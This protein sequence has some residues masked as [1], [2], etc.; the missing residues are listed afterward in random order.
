MAEYTI[1]YKINNK[2][3][4]EFFDNISN[5]RMRTSEIEASAHKA[6]SLVLL[7]CRDKKVFYYLTDFLVNNDR[8]D[9]SAIRGEKRAK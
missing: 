7:E 1:T 9:L 2:T 4:I 3:I 5:V 6:H 8:A